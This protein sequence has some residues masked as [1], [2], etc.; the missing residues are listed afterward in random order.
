MWKIKTERKTKLF[1][2]C[3]KCEKKIELFN[4]YRNLIVFC[5]LNGVIYTNLI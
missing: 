3:E 2:K 4:E 1:D 5:Y